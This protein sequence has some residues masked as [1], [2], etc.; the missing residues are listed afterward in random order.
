M[1]I[2]LNLTMYFTIF[3]K[4]VVGWS[5]FKWIYVRIRSSHLLPPLMPCEVV[6][7]HTIDVYTTYLYCLKLCNIPGEHCSFHSYTQ[8]SLV[9][10]CNIYHLQN[11]C[12]VQFTTCVVP[13]T[14]STLKG[15]GVYVPLEQGSL[16]R[17]LLYMFNDWLMLPK[18]RHT[19]HVWGS[20]AS[21]HDSFYFNLVC[22]WTVCAMCSFRPRVVCQH[23]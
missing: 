5:V 14:S 7:Q 1:L 8:C 23:G 15:N 21:L 10:I 19:V 22:L 9:Q 20:H 6:R 18:S 4:G 11:V 12:Y 16:L 17:L 3:K 13:V 2:Q